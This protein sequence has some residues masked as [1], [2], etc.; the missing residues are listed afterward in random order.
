MTHGRRAILLDEMEACR[1]AHVSVNSRKVRHN[2]LRGDRRI[3]SSTSQE[4]MLQGMLNLMATWRMLSR[5]CRPQ[6]VS[7]TGKITSTSAVL[8]SIAKTRLL[9]SYLLSG[10][11]STAVRS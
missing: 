2:S 4:R 8:S 10:L 9:S 6:A 3:I 11:Q 1:V 7:L 5:H